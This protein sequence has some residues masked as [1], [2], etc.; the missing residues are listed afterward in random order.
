MLQ[1]EFAPSTQKDLSEEREPRPEKQSIY[2]RHPDWPPLEVDFYFS[3]HNTSADSEA[4]VPH[5]HEADVYIFEG[6]D[7]GQNEL[8]WFRAIAEGWKEAKPVAQ[9]FTGFMRP[10][11]RELY[12]SGKTIAS[13]D[14]KG[15][16]EAN[17]E[18]IKNLEQA[19]MRIE[20]PPVADTYEETID[21]FSANMEKYADLQGQRE[22]LMA[23]AFEGTMDD[24]IKKDPSLKGREPL[25]VLLSMGAWHTQLRH[26]LTQAG[27]EST[28]HFPDALP[29]TY[30]FFDELTRAYSYGKQ[31]DEGLVEKAYA[32]IILEK[33]V[34]T[35]QKLQ[36]NRDAVVTHKLSSHLRDSVSSLS[37]DQI[38]ELIDAYRG[39]TLYIDDIDAM[40]EESGLPRLP[41]DPRE[42]KREVG[43]SRSEHFGKKLISVL[44][45][46]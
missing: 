44:F 38:V 34:W 8:R 15:D 41:Q 7:V 17:R 19:Q 3:P 28:R 42:F 45:R 25:K 5:L 29:H 4:L 13:I 22:D 20:A 39:N 31:P 14:V 9:S 26:R 46:K 24:L 2:E 10:I 27:V 11:M 16:S 37:H 18:L 23:A 40:L 21:A 33:A 12:G 35:S 36:K 1:P 32:Q 6:L 43:P 30:P